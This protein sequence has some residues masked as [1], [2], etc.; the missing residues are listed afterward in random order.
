MSSASDMGGSP[1]Q[2]P[3]D[4]YYYGWYEQQQQLQSQPTDGEIKSNVVNRLRENLHTKDHVLVVDV[5]KG[6][7]VMTGEVSSSVAKRAAGD[8][9]GDTPGVVDVSNQL[10]VSARFLTSLGLTEPLCGVSQS[11]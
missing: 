8:D 5:K 2:Y 1:W 9:C 6:V 10:I 4:R 3:G 7:V 11:C